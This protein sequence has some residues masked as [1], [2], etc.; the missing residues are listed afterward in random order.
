MNSFMKK[1]W[2]VCLLIAV[3]A[4]IS[5]YYIYDTNKGK[6]KGKTANGEDVVYSVNNTDVTASQFYD[7]M[8]KNNGTGALSQ[9]FVRAVT[10]QSTAV[11]SPAVRYIRQ[12]HPS[13]APFWIATHSAA[14]VLPSAINQVSSCP[15]KY[16][17]NFLRRKNP[18]SNT[19]KASTK[20]RISPTKEGK[21]RLEISEPITSP[22]TTAAI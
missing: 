16:L 13:P 15:R 11:T 2:F 6:L 7:D 8:Y 17:K 5:V 22:V 18:V 19:P 10:S 4:V 9:A 1:N 3:F 14:R 20:A 12:V 21:Y